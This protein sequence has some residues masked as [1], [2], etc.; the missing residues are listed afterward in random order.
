MGPAVSAWSVRRE[1]ARAL[2]WIALLPAL[3]FSALLLWNEWRSEHDGMVLRLDANAR[4]TANAIDDF[5]DGQLAGVRLVA[6]MK[7]EAEDADRSADLERMLRIYPAMLRG[8]YATGEGNVVAARD[9]RGRVLSLAAE[10]VAT[11]RWFDRVR[12]FGEPLVSDVYRSRIY[13]RDVVV[14]AAAPI[15]HEGR[16]DGVIH[17]A[18]PVDSFVRLNSESLRRRNFSLLLLDRSNHVVYAAPGLRLSQLDEAGEAGRAI[19]EG[20]RPASEAG[21][22]RT[23][24]DLLAQGDTAYVNAVLMRNGWVAALVAPRE[25]L[26]APILKEIGLVLALLLVTSLGVMVGLG[27]QTKLLQSSIGYLLASLHGYAI[28]GKLSPADPGRLPQEL[29]PL[30]EGIGELGGRMNAAFDELQDVLDQREH[31]IEERTESLRMV[32]SDLGR[33]SRTDALTGSLNY[34]GFQEAGERLWKEA[35]AVGGRLS[36]LALDIDHFKKYN[37]LYGHAEGDGALRR[38]AGAVSSALLHADDVLARPGG[39]EF[40]VFL[41]GSTQEQAMRVGQRVCER[42]RGA[43]IVHAASSEGRMTVSVGVASLEAADD[44]VE[45][46][47]RRADAALYRAKAAGRNRVSD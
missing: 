29:Y 3:L 37:D 7:A 4:I 30:A 34:R 45:Q 28:G 1:L 42:V 38:F 17:A 23:R 11:D 25:S 2:V 5:L 27:R 8:M 13:G 35:H 10:N 19:R 15:R 18:I 21:S 24:N 16:L 44:D 12:E 14:A 47:L 39:E 20:A 41:P 9:T 26:L 40:I 32:V 31:I 6:H 43:D 33:L 46:M 22:L 36:V